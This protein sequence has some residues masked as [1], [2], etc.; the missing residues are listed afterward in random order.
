MASNRG[1]V[2]SGDPCRALVVQHLEPESSG[3]IGEALVSNG[4]QLDV[5][6]VELGGLLPDDLG[7]YAAL[8]IMGGPMS[9]YSDEGFP[10][11]MGEIELAREALD[12]GCPFVGICLGAQL[13]AIAAGADCFAGTGSEIG[14]APISV[15]VEAAA[16]PIFSHVP[17][18]EWEVFHWHSDTFTLPEG[19][20]HLAGSAR[21]ANQAFRLGESAWGIQCHPEVD[22]HIVRGILGKFS[23]E[24]TQEEGESIEAELPA[25]LGALRPVQIAMFG[26]FARLVRMRDAR[27]QHLG[28]SFCERVRPV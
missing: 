17:S 1:G 11:R 13:L 21:Y 8:V 27:S 4:V 10:S 19:A 14:W 18:P 28:T 23:D 15:S 22:E 5:R 2:Q 6:R 3:A 24:I 7:G 9:A 20:T 12:S 25:S 16:D 26:A